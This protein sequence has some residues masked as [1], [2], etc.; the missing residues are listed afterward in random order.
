[1]QPNQQTNYWKGQ[2]DQ[3]LI[4]S[5]RSW[6]ALSHSSLAGR[7]RWR[8][9]AAAVAAATTTN[10]QNWSRLFIWKREL[11]NRQ[12]NLL[13]GESWRK[14]EEGKPSLKWLCPCGFENR[15]LEVRFFG[16]GLYTII[17]FWVEFGELRLVTSEEYAWFYF[18]YI[19][20]SPVTG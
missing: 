20:L 17:C 15:R 4:Y 14:G 7:R 1:M 12:T 6:L 19:K 8:T 16:L 2:P 18:F 9:T 11:N 13:N 5:N 10:E 3:L